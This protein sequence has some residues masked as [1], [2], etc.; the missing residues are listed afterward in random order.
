MST[1]FVARNFKAGMVCKISTKCT[2]IAATNPK[3]GRYDEAEPIEI[4]IGLASPLLSRF[5]LIIVLKDAH[6][7]AWDE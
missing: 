7:E 1:D 6:S 2:V 4:N 3:F 5:D